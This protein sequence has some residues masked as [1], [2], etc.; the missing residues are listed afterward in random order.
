MP[1]TRVIQMSV[2]WI[3]KGQCICEIQTRCNRCL[4]QVMA[5]P[6]NNVS[7]QNLKTNKQTKIW[8]WHEVMSH[9]LSPCPT[10]FLSCVHSH[11]HSLLQ[12]SCLLSVEE[13]M[14][15][16]KGPYR[17]YD[18]GGSECQVRDESSGAGSSYRQLL[19]ENSVLRERMKGLKSLGK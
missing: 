11:F 9:Y 16:G 7:H 8:M 12:D 14:M 6:M 18:P 5:G 3:A 2:F 4:Q 1:C 17:I 13:A 15:E 10:L 19:E